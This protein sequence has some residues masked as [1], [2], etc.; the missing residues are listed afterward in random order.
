MIYIECTERGSAH[1][2]TWSCGSITS[3]GCTA[4]AR[5]LPGAPAPSPASHL[6]QRSWSACL[7]KKNEFLGAHTTLREAAM[8]R[9]GGRA[10]PCPLP[11]CVS[12]AHQWVGGAISPTGL[13]P[14]AFM[15]SPGGSA[16]PCVA[17]FFPITAILVAFWWEFTIVGLSPLGQ[18][19][20]KGWRHRYPSWQ[21]YARKEDWP[22]YADH[23][24]GPED[25]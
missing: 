7:W 4:A 5:L 17:P 3:A 25:D 14:Q 12:P 15:S 1:G 10:T 11:S 21:W 24:C 6:G 22:P 2:D 8:A 20:A 18:H 9:G 19:M 16:S 23:R 13:D